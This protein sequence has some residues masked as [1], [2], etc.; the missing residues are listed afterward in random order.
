MENN[1]A[2]KLALITKKAKENKRLRFR[3]LIHHMNLE[4]LL[5]CFRSLKG[6]KAPGVDGRTFE[7]Y[8]DQE[9][10][11]TLEATIE[12]MKAKRYRPQPVRRV[13]IDKA[14]GTKRPLGI[15]T[16]LDKVVQRAITNLLIPLF[17]PLFLPVSFGFRPGTGAHDCLKQLNHIIMGQ[18]VNWIIDADIEGF[19]DHVDH[20][21][22][23]KCL[24]Q[25]ISDPNFKS[26]ILRFL[27]AGVMQE[28]VV[29]PVDR[30]T[31]QG[32]I[33]SPMLA[34][35]Y[36]HYVLDLWF[37]G[38]KKKQMN[39]YV[40]M[41]RYADDFVI[42]AQDKQEAEHILT[43]LSERLKKF[44][45]T[46]SKEKTRL[47]EFGRFAQENRS[48]RGDSKPDTFDFLGFTHYCGTTRDGRF[49][50][51]VKTSRKKMSKATQA[52]GQWLKKVRNLTTL[53]Q[54]WKQIESK[55]QGHYNYYG[56]S[57]N[58]KGVNRFYRNTCYLTFKWMNRR[59]QKKTWNWT[60]FY[61]YLNRYP[62]PKPK[63][64]YALY[65]TW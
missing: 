12:R 22:M 30:G 9:M 48:K 65:N 31:P 19:F 47:I 6:G 17:E 16:V 1:T 44:S 15:P 36:L 32:G 24:D 52:F 13:F 60:T 5:T 38:Y 64:T 28:G 45:L 10:I 7:S 57:G 58:F 50:V 27:K 62:L 14:N 29:H 25:R 20:E 49:Q 35:I 51:R 63:L 21:W 61:K 8:T 37:E 33:L 39:G 34:N 3:S 59:S 40:S 41:V 18:K 2:T 56:M 23:M 4:H 11:Q 53:P 26:L 42:L 46:L 54:I 43:Q 55:L